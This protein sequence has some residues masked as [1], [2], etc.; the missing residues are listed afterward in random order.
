[1][2]DDLVQLLGRSQFDIRKEVGYTL[3][4][5]ATVHRHLSLLVDRG[6]VTCF[7]DLLRASSSDNEAPLVALHFLEQVLTHHPSG[8]RI[9]EEAG[10]IEAMETLQVHTNPELYS[11]ASAII[12]KFYSDYSEGDLT[13]D[14]EGGM[15]T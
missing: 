14:E 5:I 9:V 6:A 4:H 11:P 2:V 15:Q 10:G 7:C 8:V 1:M 3:S 13:G 12:D